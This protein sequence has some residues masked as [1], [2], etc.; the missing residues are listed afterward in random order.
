MRRIFFG[1]PALQK[2][3]GSKNF[4][5]TKIFPNYG[6]SF[7][8]FSREAICVCFLAVV[9][10][11]RHLLLPCHT[12]FLPLP[13]PP[14]GR[15]HSPHCREVPGEEWRAEGVVRER[16]PGPLLPGQVL[17]RHQHRPTG[18]PQGLLRSHQPVSYF[19]T[20]FLNFAHVQ[21]YTPVLLYSAKGGHLQCVILPLEW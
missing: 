17:G 18:R 3:F 16:S 4:F 13:S 15:G 7:F 19:T 10:R 12:L 14:L 1:W 11:N 21:Y 5:G 8:V 9:L 2:Y 20:A 6:T